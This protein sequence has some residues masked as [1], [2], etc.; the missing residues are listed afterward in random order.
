MVLVEEVRDE[1]AFK[2]DDRQSEY[3]T[4]SNASEFSVEPEDVFD[5]TDET[6]YDRF[7]AL[8]DIIPPQTR[9]SLSRT[10]NKASSWTQWGWQ[11]TGSA[12]WIICTSTILIVLPLSMAIDDE[13]KIVQQE[14]DYQM[15]TAGQQQVGHHLPPSFRPSLMSQLLGG[16]SSTQ[17]MPGF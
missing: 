8:K 9:I 10:L 14:R 16:G 15:Q 7:V 3:E 6:L 12:A 2:E 11:K 5:P 4:E 17:G 1:T 13:M